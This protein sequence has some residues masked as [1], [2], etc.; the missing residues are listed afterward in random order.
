MDWTKD[1]DSRDEKGPGRAG[2]L[3][4]WS[5]C[6]GGPWGSL[7]GSLSVSV[8]N[9]GGVSKNIGRSMIHDQNRL[10]ARTY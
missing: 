6:R 4:V 2:P 9:H 10:Y 3:W 1:G 5:N 7:P 8:G